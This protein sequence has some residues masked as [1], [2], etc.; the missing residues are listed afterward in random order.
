MH[1]KTTI[2]FAKPAA[3]IALG[4]VASVGFLSLFLARPTLAQ[5]P[6][7]N[8][9]QDFK[10]QDGS[11]DIFS[12]SSGGQMGGILD[13]IHRANLGNIR[14]SAEFKAEQQQGLND[15]AAQFR[16]RQLELLRQSQPTP[17]PASPMP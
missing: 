7:V 10:P 13:L 11:R 14:N 6:T 2:A 12:N 16:A 17:A 3:R 4:L 1:V 15:A 5:T 9:L 8:P